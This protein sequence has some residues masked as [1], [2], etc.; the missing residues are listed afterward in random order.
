M[1]FFTGS[2]TSQ[3]CINPLLSGDLGIEE[4][5]MKSL[6]RE[7]VVSPLIGIGGSE[8]LGG[9]CAR[10]DMPLICNVVNATKTI[11]DKNDLVFLFIV[12]VS[13]G[14]G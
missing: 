4:E 7:W 6:L 8:G 5:R 1:F 2:S 13:K 12:N 11:I 3:R 9:P 10:A 14:Y